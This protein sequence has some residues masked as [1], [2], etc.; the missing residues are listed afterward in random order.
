LTLVALATPVQSYGYLAVC[1]AV[2]AEALGVP[3]PGETTLIA[4]GLYAGTTHRLS[5][6]P[7]IIA[8]AAAAIIGDNVGYLI[9]RLGGYRLL[10]RYGR[11]VRVDE[12]K[13][14]VGRYLFDRHGGKVVFLGRFVSVLRT[15]VS[16]LAGVNLMSWRRFLVYNACGGIL[17]AAL[18]SAGA[19]YLGSAIHRVSSVITYVGGAI[20]VVAAIALFF[21]LRGHIKRL[22]EVA[23]QEYPG[24]LDDPKVTARAG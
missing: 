15:Y 16:F 20:A 5:L 13:L 23:E 21:Y 7:L 6:V 18:V 4:A 10:R 8:A 19:Y 3:I 9:G 17:W 2:G 14:K 11:Y 22:E 1:L 24:P 12:A